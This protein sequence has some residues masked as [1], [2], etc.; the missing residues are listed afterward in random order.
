MNI[1][2]TLPKDDREFPQLSIVAFPHFQLCRMAVRIVISFAENL[3][4]RDAS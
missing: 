2:A 4:G 3:I 1:S